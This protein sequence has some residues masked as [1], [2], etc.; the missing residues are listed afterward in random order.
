V[1]SSHGSKNKFTFILFY[2]MSSERINL[3][4]P[5]LIPRIDLG[6]FD[7]SDSPKCENQLKRH[8]YNVIIGKKSLKHLSNTE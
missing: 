5:H 1:I 6:E 2:C 7:L 8:R 4:K 3:F